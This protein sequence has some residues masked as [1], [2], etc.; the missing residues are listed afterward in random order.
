MKEPEKEQEQYEKERDKDKE[1]DEN[2]ENDFEK[3][4]GKEVEEAIE[5]EEQEQKGVHAPDTHPQ[6]TL[7][8]ALGLPFTSQEE[9]A[10][11]KLPAYLTHEV[12]RTSFAQRKF[13]AR[14][15]IVVNYNTS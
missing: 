11:K 14:D 15:H 5:Q 9:E 2:G 4:E 8:Q 13:Y 7:V 10:V 12:F 1:T 6:L 3:R